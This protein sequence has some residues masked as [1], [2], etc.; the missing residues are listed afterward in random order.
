MG[1]SVSTRQLNFQTPA[2]VNQIIVSAVTNVASNVT[3]PLSFMDRYVTLFNDSATTNLYYSVGTTATTPAPATTGPAGTAGNAGVLGP[4]QAARFRLQTSV[5]LI[6][7]YITS[8]G[9]TT[10][11]LWCSSNQEGFALGNPPGQA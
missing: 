6:I 9:T 4:N 3:F 11:R 1:E 10:A 8:A 7:G 5:D 2:R